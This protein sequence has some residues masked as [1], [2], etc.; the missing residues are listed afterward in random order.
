MDINTTIYYGFKIPFTKWNIYLDVDTMG[1]VALS[2]ASV[3][4][5]S[6][7][8]DIIYI[9]KSDLEGVEVYSER[10]CGG[11]IFK[12]TTHFQIHN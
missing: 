5:S 12:K 1:S 2:L 3:S 11:W 8:E 4:L 6:A 10:D 7:K 9:V